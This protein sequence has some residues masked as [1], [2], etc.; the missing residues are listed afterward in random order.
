MEAEKILS[1]DYKGQDTTV[2]QDFRRERTADDINKSSLSLLIIVQN[3]TASLFKMLL[4]LRK[5]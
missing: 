2:L 3:G 1:E 4:N 5:G